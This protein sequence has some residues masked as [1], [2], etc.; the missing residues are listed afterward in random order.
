[1]T[2]LHPGLR[3]GA[4][5]ACHLPLE[6]AMREYSKLHVILLGALL[7]VVSCATTQMKDTPAPELAMPPRTA[8]GDLPPGQVGLFPGSSFTPQPAGG[9][10]PLDELMGLP[11]V[12]NALGKY[13]LNPDDFVSGKEYR[14][15]SNVPDAFQL[16]LD[17]A[18]RDTTT[19]LQMVEALRRINELV[20]WQTLRGLCLLDK[21]PQVPQVLGTSEASDLQEINRRF[22]PQLAGMEMPKCGGGK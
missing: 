2:A 1:L 12:K 17:F 5:R 16:A 18:S 14:G 6:H 11:P 4:G 20:V 9:G 15:H 13:R 19:N 8:E 22:F 10:L 21:Y 7:L 3:I